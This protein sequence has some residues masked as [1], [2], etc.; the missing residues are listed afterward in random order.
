[1]IEQ[2]RHDIADFGA[3]AP[4]DGKTSEPGFNLNGPDIAQKMLAPFR[5]DP[6]FQIDLVD[7][8]GGIAPPGV[9]QTQFA[10]FEMTAE[11]RDSHRDTF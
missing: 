6:S 11:L 8:L 10:L 4:R 2:H 1:M 5:N 9:R 3:R 7:G